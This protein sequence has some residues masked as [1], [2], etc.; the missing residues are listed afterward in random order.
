MK[1]EDRAFYR[2]HY[3]F[4]VS[5]IFAVLVLLLKYNMVTWFN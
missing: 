5:K 1:R 3:T 2:F 4:F